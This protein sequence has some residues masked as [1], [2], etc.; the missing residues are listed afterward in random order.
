MSNLIAG[1][2]K[3]W[4]LD[5]IPVYNMTVCHHRPR[6]FLIDERLYKPSFEREQISLEFEFV[7]FGSHDIIAYQMQ[8]L[9]CLAHSCNELYG[10]G[11]ST[12]CEHCGHII[13]A[14]SSAC[15][16]CGSQSI[17]FPMPDIIEI[18]MRFTDL[19]TDAGLTP[20]DT[21]P[22]RV[23]IIATV[24]NEYEFDLMV[25]R[26][27]GG[28]FFSAKSINAGYYVCA[29]CGFLA[30]KGARC[31]GCQSRQLPG[32]TAMNVKRSCIYCHQD[33]IGGIVCQNCG[34]R[35]VGDV[36]RANSMGLQ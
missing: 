23:T 11:D 25:N 18:P 32:Q 31:P 13:P 34:A 26:N 8:C 9:H 21:D 6:S 4:A 3:A 20:F 1:T 27:M 2:H 33:V 36:M 15:P 28:N 22:V 16:D 10:L 19:H 35:L 5:G 29:Y 24:G 7:L 30:R 14:G 12:G 17:V